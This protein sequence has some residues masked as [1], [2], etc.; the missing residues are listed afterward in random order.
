MRAGPFQPGGL[1][2][3]TLPAREAES[4]TEVVPQS[5]W[6]EGIGKNIQR[7]NPT[8]LRSQNPSVRDILMKYDPVFSC[9]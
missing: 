4:G 6:N 2:L 1:W 9:T 8:V 5:G 3:S 7:W